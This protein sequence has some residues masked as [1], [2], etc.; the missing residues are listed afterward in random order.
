[1]S[2]HLRNSPA[3]SNSRPVR[4]RPPFEN[5]ALL[6]Q[7]GGALGAYQGGVYEAL[8]EA[9][10]PLCGHLYWRHQWSADCRKRTEG[11]G[12]EAPGILGSIT[13]KPLWDRSEW[14]GSFLARGGDAARLWLSQINAGSALLGGA[15]GFFAPRLPPPHG[16]FTSAVS[17]A[18]ASSPRMPYRCRRHAGAGRSLLRFQEGGELASRYRPNP[19]RCRL[20]YAYRNHVAEGLRKAGLPDK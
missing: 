4:P 3:R 6:L 10:V 1:M 8:A 20:P 2:Q 18:Y 13:A 19:A 17:V 12:R 16:T 15:P 9:E 14:T 11:A 7:G 5:I